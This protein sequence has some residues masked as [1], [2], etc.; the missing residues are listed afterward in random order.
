[1]L[2]L[3]PY[4]D[5]KHNQL[6]NPL[7]LENEQ[8]Y[9]NF[10]HHIFNDMFATS[11]LNEEQKHIFDLLAFIN[12]GLHRFQGPLGSRKT[13]FCEIFDSSTSTTRQKVLLLATIGVAAL[14]LSSHALIIHWVKAW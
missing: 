3:H 4:L 2:E 10:P 8:C 6:P 1:M 12:K 11:I 9:I 13:F 5:L 14:Q 7:N